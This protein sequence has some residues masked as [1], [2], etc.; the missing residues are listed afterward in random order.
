MI[1]KYCD[2]SS[3]YFYHDHPTLKEYYRG[4]DLVVICPGCKR[5]LKTLPHPT[6]TN[7]RIIPRYTKENEKKK[8]HLF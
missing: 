3:F 6:S 2:Y 5:K 1:K 8:Y 4:C 7:G